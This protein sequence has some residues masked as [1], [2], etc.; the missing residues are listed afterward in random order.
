MGESLSKLWVIYVQDNINSFTR[1]LVVEFFVT[2]ILS[3][4]SLISFFK[5]NCFSKS[6]RCCDWGWDCRWAKLAWIFVSSW[7]SK[8]NASCS[9]SIRLRSSPVSWVR[10]RKFSNCIK[11][12]LEPSGSRVAGLLVMPKDSC[13]NT[14]FNVGCLKTFFRFKTIEK[15]LH[16]LLV[17]PASILYPDSVGLSA[18]K[19]VD[20]DCNVAEEI[21]KNDSKY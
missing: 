16:F 9:C 8:A 6:W 3:F 17:G 19:L 12:S 20:S 21:E 13:S 2:L 7:Y 18:A 1:I 10:W 14:R 4:C 5:R 15:W 11:I